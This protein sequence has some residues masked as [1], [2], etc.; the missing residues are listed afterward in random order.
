MASMEIPS[1]A[2]AIA[3]AP[4]SG[5]A[6]KPVV[7]VREGRALRGCARCCARRVQYFLAYF[8]SKPPCP[9]ITWVSFRV[10]EFKVK[11]GSTGACLEDSLGS[12][13]Y[14]AYFRAKGSRPLK[15]VLSLVVLI[16]GSLLGT[17]RGFYNTSV[18][19][20]FLA[21]SL[22]G[23]ALIYLRVH[24]RWGDVLC[25]LGGTG[26]LTWIDTSVLHYGFSTYGILALLGLA[27]IAAIAL[28]GVWTGGEEQWR[29]ALAF[30]F[31]VLS[32]GSNAVAGF[33]HNWTAKF[34]PKVLD[35]YL[36]CFDASLRVQ[37]AFLMGRAYATWNWFR[38]PGMFAYLGFPIA[39]A[40]VFAGQ[41]V[42]DGRIVLSAMIAFLLTGPVGVI[43]YTM[44]PA[45]GP[46]Y[47]FTSRYPWSPL[48][49]D[50]ASHLVLESLAIPG[51]RNSMPS[52][53]V[54]WVLLAW[55]YSVGLSFWERSIALFFVVF[56]VLATLGSG[57]HYVIDLIV[58]CP[59]ALFIY[60]LSSFYV[61]WS[62]RDRS[63]AAFVGL[64]ITLVWIELLR[65]NVKIFWIS[66]V[67][68]WLACIATVAAVIF[69]RQRLADVA[70]TPAS[71]VPV[72]A[73]AVTIS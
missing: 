3:S 33:A 7:S 70:E 29:L 9:L 1:E 68:P 64:G 44:C 24:P 13:I 4:K 14:G 19:N 60:A 46:A 10:R 67:I 15:I 49:M 18:L 25:L 59:F 5:A 66:P 34:T 53:H 35:L 31:A 56:T 8:L 69:L 43:F 73:A 47:L 11:G 2:Q 16:A 36:Y 21:F 65:F 48:T 54:A 71:P 52:L 32:V 40:L 55:W 61:P 45:L 51:L 20:V 37:F 17:G 6:A 62:N 23:F 39:V 30:L 28:R 42:R 27:S 41:L 26:L 63:L 22:A 72:A 57:E 12:V 58:A 50:Q 38:D